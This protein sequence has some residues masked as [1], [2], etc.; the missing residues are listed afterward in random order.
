MR[1]DGVERQETRGAI[2]SRTLPERP[3]DRVWGGSGSGARCAICDRPVNRDEAELEL[4]FIREGDPV[5]DAYHVH[6]RCF[7]LSG[8]NRAP[9]ASGLPDTVANASIRGR[10]RGGA[11]KSGP[12]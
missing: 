11:Y 7:A 2:Q 6:A 12:A 1:D 3:A 4:E 8:S 5:P 9:A 10:E